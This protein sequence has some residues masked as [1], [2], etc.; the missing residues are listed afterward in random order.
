MLAIKLL[1][2]SQ[3]LSSIIFRSL[4]LYLVAEVGRR[5][6]LNCFSSKSSFCCLDLAR[7]ASRILCA[8][9]ETNMQTTR[10][11]KNNMLSVHLEYNERVAREEL[12]REKEAGCG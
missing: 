12:E 6:V 5:G 9:L 7:T 2:I 8:A 11:W 1:Q 3:K 10:N 4:I